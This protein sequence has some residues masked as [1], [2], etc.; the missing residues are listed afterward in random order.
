MFVDISHNAPQTVL[1]QVGGKWSK[2]SRQ[3]ETLWSGNIEVSSVISP[4]GL[5]FS[6][7]PGKLAVER[8]AA[9][10][11]CDLKLGAKILGDS[12]ERVYGEAEWRGIAPDRI[13]PWYF[14][15]LT[16]DRTNGYGVKTCPNAMCYWQADTDGITLCMD[17][18][19]GTAGLEL[20]YEA[21]EIATVVCR[22]GIEDESS[23]YSARA[24]CAMMCDHPVIPSFPVYGGNN[25]YYAFGKTDQKQFINETKW[26]S[27]MAES[28]ENR[29]FSVI[30][31]CWQEVSLH[32]WTV[33]G[34][35]CYRGNRLFP[36]MDTIAGNVKD[37][38]ARP[39]LW[40]RPL[41]TVE[42][43]P[44]SWLLPENRF[45]NS[46][47]EGGVF[48]PTIPEA[49]EHIGKDIARFSSWGFELVKHDFTCF[50]ITGKWGYAMH[51]QITEG[52]WSFAD[53]NKTTAQAIKDLYR[54]IAAN[55]GGML[56]IGC[57]TF[58]HLSAGIFHMQRIGDDSGC[59]WDRVRKMGINPLAF[60]MPQ[61]EAFYA[62]DADCVDMNHG[63]PWEKSSLW[64]DLLSK[65]GTPLFISAASDTINKTQESAIREAFR[66]AAKKHDIAEPLDWHY[67]T[68]PI[69]WSINGEI[70]TYQWNMLKGTPAIAI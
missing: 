23:F 14:F 21:L 49:L 39:G 52:T 38:G 11:K 22:Q 37:S 2:L 50:D 15:I 18:R 66:R 28:S 32:G 42:N 67:T 64:L 10:W 19:C 40:C 26:I 12:W 62:V 44:Q 69:S 27:E 33:A 41:L 6:L 25:W 29:P 57:N 1:S 48:D 45:H 17:V 9:Y 70:T 7:S 47:Y 63:I 8:I 51:S 13:M 53:K 4:E 61:H 16:D 30:D 43:V 35:P 59:N 65:S 68:C 20:S 55:A 3:G 46:V 56:I 60:R 5:T 34:G 54:T 36:N 31:A 58:S 24:F